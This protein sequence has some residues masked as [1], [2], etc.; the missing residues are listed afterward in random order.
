MLAVP[1]LQGQSVR[2]ER[3]DRAALA[4]VAT[5]PIERAREQSCRL[6]RVH[7][8]RRFAR[9]REARVLGEEEPVRA[10]GRRGGTARA[11]A[12]QYLE[13]VLALVSR[14]RMRERERRRERT[15]DPVGPEIALHPRAARHV[16]TKQ[17]HAL[18]ER[19]R[20]AGVGVAI[21]A[22]PAVLAGILDEILEEPEAHALEERK[23]A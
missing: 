3:R 7:R 11:P 20:R 2:A 15:L 23:P 22:P 8:D 12:D 10:R 19:S 5:D 4:D 18:H 16:T 9:L 17:P 6:D 21:V 13:E 14:E 1:A